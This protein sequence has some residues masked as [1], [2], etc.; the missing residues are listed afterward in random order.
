[1]GAKDEVSGVFRAEEQGPALLGRSNASAQ[2]QRLHVLSANFHVAGSRGRIQIPPL[3]PFRSLYPN[4]Q[5]PCHGRK[6]LGPARQH[7]FLRLGILC[8]VGLKEYVMTLWF[9]K[10]QV[11]MGQKPVPQ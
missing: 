10:H 9:Y 7:V 1:M 8:L 5:H 6:W 2:R 4:K 11:S 3:L